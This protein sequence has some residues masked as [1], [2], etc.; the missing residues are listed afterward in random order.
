MFRSAEM[1]RWGGRGGSG[2]EDKQFVNVTGHVMTGSS[3]S[4]A[5]PLLQF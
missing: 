5:V 1:K 4:P 3:L 2:A